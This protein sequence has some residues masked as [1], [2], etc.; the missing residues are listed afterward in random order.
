M[1]FVSSFGKSLALQSLRYQLLVILEELNSQGTL[2]L[3]VLAKLWIFAA[4][5][6]V[7]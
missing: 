5:T 7:R 4:D 2:S 6:E 3:D 1:R